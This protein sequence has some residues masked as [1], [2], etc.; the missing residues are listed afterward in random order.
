MIGRALLVLTTMAIALLLASGAALAGA[1]TKTNAPK[2]TKAQDKSQDTKTRSASES[3]SGDVDAQ[4]KRRPPPPPTSTNNGFTLTKEVSPETAAVGD[5]VTFTIT[6]T[7]NSGRELFFNVGIFDI[8][9]KGVTLLTVEGPPD[10]IC[11]SKKRVVRCSGFI[12]ENGETATMT[13]TVAPKKA[14]TFR[15]KANDTSFPGNKVS[16]PFTV[17]KAA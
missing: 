4:R 10:A 14:G 17:T 3:T 6:E 13:I 5:E 8:L 12:I 1:D 15:N 9:P 11:A 16:V 7:N 2:D